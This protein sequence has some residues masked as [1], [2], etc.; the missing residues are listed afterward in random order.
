MIGER[1]YQLRKRY[2]MS[3]REL[4][5]RLAVSHYTVSSYE[6]GRSDPNDEIKMRIAQV[7]DVSLDY[8]L[9]LIDEPLPYRRDAEAMYIPRNLDQGQR[10]MVRE[11]LQYM[12]RT[13]DAA[14]KRK[15]DA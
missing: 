8:L 13:P 11:F 9:G 1:L 12:D 2:G 4:A 3:Q 5:R 15:P 14:A 10:R 7:F 6:N